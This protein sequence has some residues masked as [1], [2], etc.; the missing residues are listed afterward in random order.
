[1]NYFVQRL[2]FSILSL[3][4]LVVITFL[5]SHVVW[6]GRLGAPIST[7]ST[8]MAI[9]ANACASMIAPKIEVAIKH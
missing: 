2:A 9:P 7:A 1:M 4:V 6:Q 3:F 8:G 5:L